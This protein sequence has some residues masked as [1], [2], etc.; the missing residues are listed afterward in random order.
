VTGFFYPTAALVFTL[1]LYYQGKLAATYGAR[2]Y[3]RAH[4]C[5]HRLN[6]RRMD[7]RA[8]DVVELAIAAAQLTTALTLAALAY[9]ARLPPPPARA[10]YQV[11]DGE[12]RRVSR[13]CRL[14]RQTAHGVAA[15]GQ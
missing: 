3:R 5:T 15:V 14:T 7:R 6:C 8:A 13:A 12:G 1:E 2:V 4:S 10:G 11:W 9:V